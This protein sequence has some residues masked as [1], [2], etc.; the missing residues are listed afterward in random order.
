[1][2]NGIASIAHILVCIRSALRAAQVATY[3]LEDEQTALFASVADDISKVQE[4]PGQTELHV[5]IISSNGI[6]QLEFFIIG[7]KVWNGLP[8]MSSCSFLRGDIRGGDLSLQWSMGQLTREA[9]AVVGHHDKRCRA[10]TRKLD[11][12]AGIVHDLQKLEYRLTCWNERVN[13]CPHCKMPDE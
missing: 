4:Q 3:K 5:C 10:L 13:E 7:K 6:R 9:I 11:E 8:L 2:K 1:M 12:L